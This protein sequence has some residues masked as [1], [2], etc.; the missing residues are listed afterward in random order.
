MASNIPIKLDVRGGVRVGALLHSDSSNA[1]VKTVVS[2]DGALNG[3]L[4][5]PSS[6]GGAA[7]KAGAVTSTHIAPGTLPDLSL[8]ATKSNPTFSGDITTQ[9]TIRAGKAYVDNN[10]IGEPTAGVVGGDGERVV[11]WPGTTSTPFALGIGSLALWSC[12]PPTASHKWYHGTTMT[13]QLKAGNFTTSGDIA[14]STITAGGKQVVDADGLINGANI[15]NNTITSNMIKPGQINLAHLAPGTIP[16]SNYSGSA[17]L[18]NTYLGGTTT[19][20]E[21]VSMGGRVI[22]GNDGFIPG[23]SIASDSIDG[24]ALKDSSVSAVKFKNLT[25]SNSKLADQAVTSS[26]IAPEAV[27]ITHLAPGTIPVY[28]LTG[29]AP[30][31]NGLINGALIAPNTITS[32]KIAPWAVGTDAI[33]DKAVTTLKLANGAVNSNQLAAGAVNSNHLAPGT[34]PPPPNLSGYAPLLN[35]ALTG[36]TSVQQLVGNGGREVVRPD[37]MINGSNLALGSVATAALSNQS[38]TSDKLGAWA[39]TVTKIA[40]DSVISTKIA[41]SNVTTAHLADGAVTTAKLAA[42]AVTSNILAPGTIPPPPDLSAYAPINNATLTGTTTV[43]RILGGYAREVVNVNGQLVGANLVP[44]SVGSNAIAF[45][46]INSNLIEDGAIVSSKL[47][48]GAVLENNLQAA[49]V[50]RT[51]IKNYT[52]NAI[53]LDSDAVITEKIAAN[54]VTTAKLAMGA[55]NSNN[56]ANGAVQPVHIAAEAIG[57]N[58]LASLAVTG[59]KIAA[60]AVSNTNLAPDSVSTDKLQLGCVTAEKIANGALHLAAYTGSYTD[61]SNKPIISTAG[62]TGNYADLIDKPALAPVALTGSYTDLINVPP[63]AVSQDPTFTTVTATNVVSGVGTLGPTFLMQWGYQDV[64]PGSN[65]LITN[66]EPGADAAYGHSFPNGFLPLNNSG[67]SINWDVARLIIRGRVAPTSGTITGGTASMRLLQGRYMSNTYQLI[68]PFDVRCENS[69]YGY[70]T[71]ITPWFKPTYT[72][73]FRLYLDVLST[74][75]NAPY[76][77]GVI[78]IQFGTAKETQTP[79]LA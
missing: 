2:A 55:V 7:I 18:S 10:K 1:V 5:A 8:Y 9:S 28:D 59:P 57:P 37:G 41:A 66:N 79:V 30:L 49:S 21:V 23:G 27:N 70:T 31:S 4:L 14:A 20:H 47:G 64:L 35:T 45:G 50:S 56:I 29:Y 61:L 40:N 25:I 69:T 26:K 12:V 48:V 60:G 73:G 15:R 74:P 53:L 75:E 63:T 62:R 19:V 43:N 72:A 32:G 11:F 58:K 77:V 39:V 16:L 24:G 44:R 67:E 33:A 17:S 52:I 54:A 38:V 78:Y 46:A 34:I 22:V 76:R 65:L 68:A 42:G 13:T 3:E 6:V 51:K 71:T 36:T